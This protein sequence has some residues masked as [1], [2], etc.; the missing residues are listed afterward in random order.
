M[1]DADDWPLIRCKPQPVPVGH[2]EHPDFRGYDDPVPDPVFDYEG[3][4]DA[5]LADL[6][7]VWWRK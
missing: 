4:L 7:A 5:V 3:D 6:T 2:P 1:S